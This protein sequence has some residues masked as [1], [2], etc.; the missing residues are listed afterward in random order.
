MLRLAR[1]RTLRMVNV[2]DR[3][4]KTYVVAFRDKEMIAYERKVGFAH[5]Y[6]D[7]KEV[8]AKVRSGEL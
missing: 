6:E 4:R 8:L 7:K 3:V 1:R 2:S 5:S